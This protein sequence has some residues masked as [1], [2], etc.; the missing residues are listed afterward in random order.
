LR[1]AALFAALIVAGCAAR[2]PAPVAPAAFD[3]PAMSPAG[4]APLSPEQ[5]R[6]LLSPYRERIDALD[7]Q[8]VALLGKRFDIVREVAALKAERGIAPILPDR[9]EEVVARA[10]AKA[11]QEGV[12]PKLVEQIYRIMIDEACKLEADYAAH[13]K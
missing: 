8:I 9:I 4:T 13:R 11:E 10:R 1:P 6:A 3:P 2:Q 12:D 5:Q 7:D